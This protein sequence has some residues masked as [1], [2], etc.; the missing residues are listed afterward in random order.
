MHKLRI[1]C[2]YIQYRDGVP[3][4]DRRRLY[5]HA[6]L[7]LTE[8][9]IVNSLVYL[10]VKISKVLCIWKGLRTDLIFKCPRTLR[11][12]I[13]RSSSIRK[14]VQ[15]KNM[16]Y[17][18]LS[19]FWRQSSRFFFSILV[20]KVEFILIFSF[21]F[22]FIRIKSTIDWIL[23]H[24]HTWKMHR[25]SCRYLLVRHHRKQ[26]PCVVKSLRGIEHPKRRQFWT[27]DNE[28]LSSLQVAWR[29]PRLER[30]ISYPIHYRKISTLVSLAKF[31]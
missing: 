27:I 21:S 29:I 4:E 19:L 1:I 12:K 23:P 8:Q 13:L 2:L 6:R 15:A 18:D 17:L 25:R 31:I 10:G 24:F 16:S 14:Q 20:E 22:L 9:D 28:S 26:H 7:T 5:Q 3:D 11:I 30:H